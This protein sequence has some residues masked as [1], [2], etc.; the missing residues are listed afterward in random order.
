MKQREYHEGKEAL[1]IFEKG[2][3]ALFRVPKD[4][5]KKPEKPKRK[6]QKASKD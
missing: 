3:A 2:M 5:V 4:V 1:K 6:E